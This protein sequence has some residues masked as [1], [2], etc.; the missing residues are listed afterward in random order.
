MPASIRQYCNAF[1]FF[2]LRLIFVG[3]GERVCMWCL[4]NLFG[5]KTWKHILTSSGCKK[6]IK[7]RRVSGSE[8]LN[9]FNSLDH[10]NRTNSKSN[11]TKHS[12]QWNYK[13]S[14]L[15]THTCNVQSIGQKPQNHWSVRPQNAF[16]KQSWFTSKT[17]LLKNHRKCP[18]LAYKFQHFQVAFI[19]RRK[20]ISRKKY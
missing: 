20:N 16:T 4:G 10:K 13:S 15:S 17:T 18:L 9:N 2:F 7:F 3:R 5:Y 14:Q 8:T 6:P 19:W 1:F 12:L 11:S